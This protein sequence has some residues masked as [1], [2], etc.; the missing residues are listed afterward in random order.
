M[1]EKNYSKRELD[2]FFVEFDKRMSHQDDLLTE[3]KM[4]TTRT[5]GRVSKLEFWI[6]ALKWTCG[7]LWTLIP[8][9]F[10]LLV[11]LEQ[12][13]V[14]TDSHKAVRDV[15]NQYNIQYQSPK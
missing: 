1:Q 12:L 3:I 6:T 9:A 13:Q 10:L 15:L 4:Q 7:V 2:N 5:N 14:I 8:L 11:H